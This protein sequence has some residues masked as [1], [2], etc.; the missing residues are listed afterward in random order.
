M[1]DPARIPVLMDKLQEVWVRYP[2]LRFGQL[3]E[4]II[5]AYKPGTPV[6]GIER[7]LWCWEETTWMEAIEKFETRY[8]KC[9]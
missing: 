2:D 9:L 7:A 1:R 3:L 5:H 6:V 8:E 4:N